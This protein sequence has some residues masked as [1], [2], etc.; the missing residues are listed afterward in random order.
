MHGLKEQDDAVKIRATALLEA[1]AKVG[2]KT[3]SADGS[4]R[5]GGQGADQDGVFK[6]TS[7]GAIQATDGALIIKGDAAA[8]AGRG[9]N[10]HGSAPAGAPG[11][12]AGAAA[13]QAAGAAPT[14]EAYDTETSNRLKEVL[15]KVRNAWPFRFGRGKEA[16]VAAPESAPAAAD[17]APAPSAP[18][19]AP[20]PATA[21][22]KI[23]EPKKAADAAPAAEAEA[24]AEGAESAVPPPAQPIKISTAD[25][26]KEA[27]KL[28]A[29][30]ETG[31]EKTVTKAQGEAND[32]KKEM[33]STRA[34]RWVDGLMSELVAEKARLA[35]A[36]KALNTSIRQK[37]IEFRTKETILTEE[38][39]RRDDLIR[40][41]TNAL[42]RLK[43]Q[44]SQAAMS[45]ERLKAS[46]GGAGDDAH[47]K[48]KYGLVQKMLN[49]AKEENA[50]LTEKIE[51]LK[52]QLMSAQ[53]SSSKRQG[54]SMTDFSALQAK[55]ERS[56][57]QADEFKKTNQQ[58]LDKLAEAKK[59]RVQG[60]AEDTKKRLEAA[61]KMAT[62][63]QRDSEK[64][65]V[66]VEEMQREHM[67]LQAELN[68]AQHEL[69]SARVGAK[70]GA[71]PAEGAATAKPAAGMAASKPAASK[72][73]GAK[74]GVSG[75]AGVSSKPASAAAKPVQPVAGS[76]PLAG[77]KPAQPAG[78]K[79]AQPATTPKPAQPAAAK[80]AQPA[81][82]AA[83]PA[84]PA[85]TTAAKPG[86]GGKSNPPK[87]A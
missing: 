51:D 14:Q 83:K 35:E 11:E 69:K 79:P 4:T 5:V 68:K 45:A 44:L 53:L 6:V 38:L 66:R 36:S 42:N 61:M 1:I 70:A 12:A 13:P 74:P 54:P 77:A 43:D 62:N 63:Y 22:T 86:A 60:G 31:I 32:V 21:E 15:E 23:A 48:Q 80:P 27:Q 34:K 55:Y 67:R 87:A 7:G 76:K 39:K 26:A 73:A 17:A 33:G 71:A 8:N 81:T 16:P 18:A 28:T 20:A 29:E 58:L 59:E 57:R 2:G 82:A 40:Q 72:L 3:E 10:V 78:A 50:E 37:E 41:K 84:Q 65:Q 9:Y 52:N 47:Y 75:A 85:A 24:D 64:L 19:E 25:I 46:K 30:I 56:L 49:S